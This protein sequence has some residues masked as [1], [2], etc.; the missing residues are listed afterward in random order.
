M[1]VI[2]ALLRVVTAI[3]HS[4]EPAGNVFHSSNPSH[5]ETESTEKRGVLGPSGIEARNVLARYD[6]HVHRRL[7]VD[8]AKGDNLV[9]LVDNIGRDLTQRD[10]AEQAGRHA[11]V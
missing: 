4:P 11:S 7:W 1:E 10:L 9:V 8:I 5:G 2:H 6:K 3:N